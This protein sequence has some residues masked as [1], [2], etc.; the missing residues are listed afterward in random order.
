MRNMFFGEE[1]CDVIYFCFCIFMIVFYAPNFVGGVK[2]EGENMK[3]VM[4]I[5]ETS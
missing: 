5:E 4:I 2:W 3:E 1:I